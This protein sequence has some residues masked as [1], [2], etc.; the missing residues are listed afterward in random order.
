MKYQFNKNYNMKKKRDKTLQKQ[1]DYRNKRNTDFKDL[2]RS[3]VEI[4]NKSKAL[5]KKVKINDSE[6]H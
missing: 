1:N 3:Y 6:K 4:Q 5:K 2:H